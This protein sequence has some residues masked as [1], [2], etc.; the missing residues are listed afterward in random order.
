MT[1]KQDQ[2][3]QSGWSLGDLFPSSESKEYKQALESLDQLGVGRRIC[4]YCRDTDRRLA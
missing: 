3:K 4:I 1:N 2:F